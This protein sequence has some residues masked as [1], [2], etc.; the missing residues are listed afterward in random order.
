MTSNPKLLYLTLGTLIIFCLYANQVWALPHRLELK[1]LDIGQGD[2][3][4]ITTP[5]GRTMLIDGGPGVSI[6]ERL[7]EHTS[8]WTD[9]FDLLL[10][11]HPDLDHLEGLVE[12]IQRY[13]VNQVMLTGVIHHS[14][15]YR[16]F[17]ELLS[18]KN[19]PLI[20]VNPTQDWQLDEEVF[21]DIIW[22]AGDTVLQEY[23]NLNDTSITIRLIYRDTSI[24]LPGDIESKAEH[25]ILMSDRDIRADILKSGHHGSQT[26]S[27]SPFL[28]AV[29]PSSIIIQSGRENPFNHP[30]LETVLRYDQMDVEWTNTKDIGTITIRSDGEKWEL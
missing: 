22:P 13:Q 4:L 10:L 26:S 5:H 14:N 1:F 16:A 12:V 7:G 23:D 20:I 11:T 17:L 19:I 9:Q 28:R 15:L 25:S 30:H 3:I 2:S 29:N 8:F 21:L 27:T 6:L 24:L 18:Q